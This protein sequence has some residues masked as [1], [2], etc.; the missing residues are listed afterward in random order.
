MWIH[1]ATP[2]NPLYQLARDE[3]KTPLSPVVLYDSGQ[4]SDADG[5]P[6]NMALYAVS[7]AQQLVVATWVLSCR[8]SDKNAAAAQAP[9]GSSAAGPSRPRQQLW[10]SATVS[11][12][13]HNE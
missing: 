11:P 10:R 9:A 4:V 8:I 7:K 13:A 12:T 5:K 3:L 2:A 1:E 6:V